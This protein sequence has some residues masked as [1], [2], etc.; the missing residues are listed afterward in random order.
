MKPVIAINNDL[1][2]ELFQWAGGLE[3]LTIHTTI[4]IIQLEKMATT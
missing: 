1:T 2:E 3:L 4:C